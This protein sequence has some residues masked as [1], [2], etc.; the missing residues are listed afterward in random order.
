MTWPAFYGQIPVWKDG[1][2]GRVNACPSD[3]LDR[4]ALQ[5]EVFASDLLLEGVNISDKPPMVIGEP[6]GQPSFVISQSL[7]A[8]VD[9]L[10]PTPTKEQIADFMGEFG[11]EPIAGSF[12]GWVRRKDR[13]A[14]VD[15]KPDNFIFS[16]KGVTPIDLQMTRLPESAMPSTEG[17]SLIIP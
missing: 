1:A 11:F 13:V 15:A 4:H 8:A 3:Y 10:Q 14:V 6:S 7:I 16:S 17:S 5:N 2:L 9:A 12:H